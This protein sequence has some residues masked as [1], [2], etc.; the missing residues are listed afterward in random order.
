MALNYRAWV[1]NMLSVMSYLWLGAS[2]I[3]SNVYFIIIRMIIFNQPGCCC[4]VAKSSP[5]LC[6]PMDCSTLG[7]PVLH[8][9]L[10]FAQTHI[11]SQWCHPTISSSAACFSSCPQSFLASRYFPMSWLFA[12]GGQILIFSISI[13][14]SNEYSGLISFKIDWFHLAIQGTQ[15]SSPAP[16]FESINSSTLSLLYGPSLSFVHDYWINQLWLYGPLLAKWYL[17]FLIHHPGLS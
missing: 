9:F 13:N 2:T 1:W 6:D 16:Q 14:S 3:W 15:E 11:L 8:Y 4:L 7:F 5:T 10:E 17:C 12:S